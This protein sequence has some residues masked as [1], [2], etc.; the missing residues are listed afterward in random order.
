MRSHSRVS[1]LVFLHFILYIDFRHFL[2]VTSLS[3]KHGILEDFDE[4]I[5]IPYRRS[6]VQKNHE[7]N[8]H[9]QHT[10][11]EAKI[12]VDQYFS[13]A[14]KKLI[15][16]GVDLLNDSYPLLTKGRIPDDYC[17]I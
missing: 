17:F 8:F 7:G 6:C 4:K 14:A 3:F 12:F 10:K 1:S 11:K 2:N 5:E 13:E 15:N 16:K 9:R